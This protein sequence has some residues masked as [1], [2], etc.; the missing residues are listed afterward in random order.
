VSQEHT[1]VDLGSDEFTV[2][3]LHP[4]LD[5]SVRSQRLL[6]EARDPEVAVLLVD[7]VLGFGAHPDPAAELAQVWEEASRTARRSG[8]ELVCVASVCGTELDPQPYGSQVERLQGSGVVVA[9]TNAA[10]AR[11]AGALCRRAGAPSEPGPL[12]TVDLRDGEAMA[13]EVSPAVRELLRGP[14]RAVN[15]GLESFAQS[16]R[17]QGV[18]VVSVDWKPPAAGDSEL[19]EL[20]SRLG[21]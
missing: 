1:V 17:A 10:A 11:L 20:L 7:V 19:L 14:V 4:M 16:L 6:Q 2:G 13:Y 3:R 18:P 21:G 8:R 15:V 5:P 12:P 9:P